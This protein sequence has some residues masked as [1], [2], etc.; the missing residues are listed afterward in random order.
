MR[1]LLI[2]VRNG[3]AVPRGTLTA[4]PANAVRLTIPLPAGH[5]WSAGQHYFL[6]FISASSFESHPYT[7]ANAPY[8]HPNSEAPERMMV[9][10]LRVHP[11]K[12]L[13]PKLLGLA[14]SGRS[15][16]V[17]LDGPYGGLGNAQIGRH[18]TVLLL[19]GGAGASF[20]AA[21]LEEVCEG[22]RRQIPGVATKR[23]ELVWV[24]RDEGA[25]CV[26]RCAKL[27]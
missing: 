4:L 7:I 10:V 1:F 14:A 15:T 17:L 2:F 6:N 22:I 19:A 26:F 23:V 27:S 9:V 16:A 20:I 12:G 18:E 25:F 3:R 11:A 24:V 13:G 5:R 21:L 8:L